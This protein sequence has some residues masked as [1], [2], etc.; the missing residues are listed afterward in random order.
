MRFYWQENDSEDKNDVQSVTKILDLYFQAGATS[1]F[2]DHSFNYFFSPKLPGY[3]FA[4]LLLA[5]KEINIVK[6]MVSINDTII[7]HAA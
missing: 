6:I 3:V 4:F 1:I 7:A 5:E 2:V